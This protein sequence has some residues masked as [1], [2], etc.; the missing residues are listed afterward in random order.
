MSGTAQKG[1]TL[2]ELMVA[3][4]IGSIAALVIQQ[5]MAVFEGQ[6]R[7][8]SGGSDAQVNGAVALFS[9]EREIR[10][11]GYGL[12]SG[13]GLLCPLG[14]NIYYNG[15]TVSNGG[16]LRPL[17]ILDGAAGPDAIEFLRSDADFGAVPTSIIKNMPNASAIITADT[18]GGLVENQMFLA[19]GKGGGKVCTLMQMSQDAQQTGNGWDLQHNP[20]SFPYNP[21]NPNTA[22]AVA[23]TYE[24]GDSVVNMGNLVHG[25]YQ[26]LCERLTEVNPTT[27]AAPYTCANTTPLVD[28]IIDLQAQYGIA[29]VGGTQITQWCNATAASVCGD[30]S[31]PGAAEVPRIRAV[32]IAVVARSVQYEREQVSPA[33]LTLWDVGDPGDVPPIR[34]LSDDERHYRYKVFSTIVPIRNVIWGN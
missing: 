22:F 32:R 8:S 5:A 21:P 10:Q 23:P 20:G 17:V 7:T 29:A 33:S 13:S 12:F 15:T 34:A 4:V 30:W 3:L 18:P 31:N 27:T 28:Q 6:K 9:L 24:I 14:I 25:R 2:V 26:V 19:T 11:A 1:V 16:A